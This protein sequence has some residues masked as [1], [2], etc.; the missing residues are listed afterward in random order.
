MSDVYQGLSFWK[1]EK[2][3]MN[4]PVVSV[5]VPVYNTVNYIETTLNALK[6]Q[7]LSNIEIILIDDGSTDGSGEICDRYAEEDF[8]FRVIHQEN[9]GVSVARNAGIEA[10]RGRYIGFCDSDDI[11][12]RDLYETLYDLITEEGSDLAMV[13]ASVMYCDGTVSAEETHRKIHF[14]RNEDALKLFLLE[15]IDMSVYTKLISASICKGLCFE[16]G[17]KIHEDKFFVFGMILAAKKISYKDSCKYQYIRRDGSSSVSKFTEKYLDIIYFADRMEQMVK[18][19]Y[20]ELSEYATINK[21]IAYLRFFHDRIMLGGEQEFKEETKRLKQYLK[22]VPTPLCKKYLPKRLYIKW[23]IF[24]LGTL[25]YQWSI[26][27][28]AHK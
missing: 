6:Y 7:T 8:R 1:G 3:M 12:Q 9:Q 20:P 15:Q 26:R 23:R 5:I 21:V 24:K 13:K 27:L 16:A 28:F 4:Q 19:Q 11:P 25:P 2:P 10:A 22:H 17:R 18:E 14:V